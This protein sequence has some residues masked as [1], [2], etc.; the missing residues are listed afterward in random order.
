MFKK[1][2]SKKT[3]ILLFNKIVWPLKQLFPHTC[4]TTYYQEGKKH[5]CVWKMWLG[6]CFDID[7]VVISD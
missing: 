2:I 3:R 4:R 6:R 7:D 5:F 1:F